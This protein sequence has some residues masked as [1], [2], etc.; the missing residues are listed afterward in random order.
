MHEVFAPLE[1]EFV[2]NQREHFEVV[3]LF[4][5][6][7]VDH[8]VDGVVGVSLCG[9]ADV[10]CHVHACSVAAQKQ[11]VIKP[12]GGEVG[13]YGAILAAVHDAFFESFKHFFFAVEVGAAF[14]IYFVEVHTHAAVCG[15]ESGVDP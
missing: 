12:V 1:S 6:Y 15:V 8:A 14:I 4:V 13:P 9:C 3:F 11:F 5:A 7:D 10:L 2:E